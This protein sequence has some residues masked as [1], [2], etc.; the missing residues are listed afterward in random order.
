MFFR[1]CW[2]M[3]NEDQKPERVPDMREA[4]TLGYCSNMNCGC[5]RPSIEALSVR[6]DRSRA[7]DTGTVS[8]QGRREG[9]GKRGDNERARKT[10]RVRKEYATACALGSSMQDCEASL[11]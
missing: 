1:A 11:V 4:H 10:R 9:L 7:D 5:C 2:D 8:E 3:Y 6:E